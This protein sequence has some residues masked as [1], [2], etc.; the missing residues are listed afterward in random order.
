MSDDKANT[1]GGSVTVLNERTKG[2]LIVKLYIDGRKLFEKRTR[3]NDPT[4]QWELNP[5]M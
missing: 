2:S 4:V 3:D 5:P 1:A